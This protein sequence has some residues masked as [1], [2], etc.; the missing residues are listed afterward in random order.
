MFKDLG[1]KGVKQAIADR[2]APFG[3]GRVRV[4]GPELRDADGRLLPEEESGS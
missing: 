3:D 2:D 4:D 1:E